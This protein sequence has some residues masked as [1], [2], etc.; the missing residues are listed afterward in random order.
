MDI[1]AILVSVGGGVISLGLGFIMWYIKGIGTTMASDKLICDEN[2]KQLNNKIQLFELEVA[3]NYS[4]KQ[5]FREFKDWLINEFK[6]IKDLLK[7]KQD[8]E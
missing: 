2:F 3:R 6:E 5:D 4:T 7:N 8:K 1:T